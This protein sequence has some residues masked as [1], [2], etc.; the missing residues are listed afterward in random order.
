MR[1]LFKKG[2][3]VVLAAAM[4]LSLGFGIGTVK[5]Q[6]V[7]AEQTAGAGGY[8]K[9]FLGFQVYPSWASRVEWNDPKMGLTTTK[10]KVGKKEYD[11]NYLA[12]VMVQ[13]KAYTGTRSVGFQ[14]A[15]M[16]ADG[17]YTVSVSD[18]DMTSE[19]LLGMSTINY[20][21]LFISTNI[22]ISENDVKCTDVKLYIDGNVVATLDE[23]N[24]NHEDS[25]NRGC[26]CFELADHWNEPHGIK[27][28]ELLNDELIDGGDTSNDNVQIDS[29][30]ICKN[31]LAIEYTIS[32]VDWDNV[33]TVPLYVGPAEEQRITCQEG[34]YEVITRAMDN[35]TVGEVSLVGLTAKGKK[36]TE[37]KMPDYII[38]G[39]LKYKVILLAEN[40]FRKN[41]TIKKV[42]LNNVI[43]T[44]DT[45]EFKGC[46]KL[47]TV[48]F[49]KKCRYLIDEA[50]SGCTS[51]KSITIPAKV[52]V[53]ESE[54][55]SG[56]TKLALVKVNSK[57][58]V[59]K[60]A[61]KGC[62]KT[63]KVSGK[64]ADKQYFVEQVKKS[65]YNK[66]K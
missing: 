31:S 59:R 18:F 62:K 16:T 50:F 33:K 27:S 45:A 21:R 2:L 9:A 23:A 42:T 43:D 6:E 44:V 14:D 35:G 4:V 22:P 15:M 24:Y 19:K 56:C 29:K 28:E 64:K 32:G 58:K 39:G 10:Y 60:N 13:N 49:G 7:K 3:S 47:T 48:I 41:T 54:V 1:K 63:I 40:V 11:Y 66:V 52:R 55:F 25:T 20:K 61:F 51:L 26:Y 38:V 57:V 53:I 34:I 5:A 17:T 30:Y 37:F 12:D 8:Y 46:K 65:G 36:M